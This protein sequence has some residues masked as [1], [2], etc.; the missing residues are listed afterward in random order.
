MKNCSVFFFNFVRGQC[1][2][3]YERQQ[4]FVIWRLQECL[5]RNGS[6]MCDIWI[7][8]Y[9]KKCEFPKFP[10]STSSVLLTN[11]S[12]RRILGYHGDRITHMSRHEEPLIH[13]NTAVSSI[14]HIWYGTLLSTLH[15]LHNTWIKGALE[16]NI[17]P[18]LLKTVTTAAVI[19]ASENSYWC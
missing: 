9:S 13:D 12:C 10:A 17:L 8:V 14:F 6:W 5:C 2:G 18:K 3:G 7:H 11:C 4:S 15:I 1:V 16:E 19:S